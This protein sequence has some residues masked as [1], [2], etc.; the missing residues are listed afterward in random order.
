MVGTE[1]GSQMRML[2]GRSIQAKA[3]SSN[4]R[5]NLF[6]REPKAVV[7]S[8]GSSLLQDGVDVTLGSIR[9]FGLLQRLTAATC[10]PMPRPVVDGD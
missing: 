3:A 8:G 10:S 9:I 7:E 6:K 1:I 2:V 5:R 4:E